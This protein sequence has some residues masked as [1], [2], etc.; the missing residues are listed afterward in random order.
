MS[1][2]EL[3]R[4]RDRRRARIDDAAQAQFDR[5]HE[6]EPALR[7]YAERILGEDLYP[8][9]ATGDD[10]YLAPASMA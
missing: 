6:V 7:A 9:T 3:V 1:H 8:I 5:G 2:A 4:Q 10:G